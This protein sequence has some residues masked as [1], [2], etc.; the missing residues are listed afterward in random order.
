MGKER[1]IILYMMK[2]RYMIVIDMKFEIWMIVN[3]IRNV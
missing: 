3:I 2:V 1:G